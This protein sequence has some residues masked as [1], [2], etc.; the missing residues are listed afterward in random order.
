VAIASAI[1]LA[2][3]LLHAQQSSASAQPSSAAKQAE[4]KAAEEGD[5][6]FKWIIM[7]A[8]KPRKATEAKAAAVAAPAAPPAKH[9]AAPAPAPAAR[10]A[11]DEGIT[12]RVTPLAPA[13]GAAVAASPAS[14]GAPVATAAPAP[15]PA[16]STP[17]TALALAP[18]TSE[19]PPAP[20]PEPEEEDEPLVM[21]KSADP[22]MP[23][24]LLTGQM[25]KGTVQVRF[26]VKPDGSVDD[27]EVVKST[28][29]KLN[30]SATTAVSQWRFKPIKHA[31]YGMVEMVFDPDR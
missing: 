25:T 30:R 7:H 1:L 23:R 6:V 3:P 18:K 11:K 8:E 10:R 28:Q 9:A 21:V 13:A 29:Q 5:K 4:A 20:E 17:S 27:V 15:A 16:A 26:E 12:E 22:E 24:S 14:A 2:A 31:Q 19:P